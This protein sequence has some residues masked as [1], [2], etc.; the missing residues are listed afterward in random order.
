MRL[1]SNLV[2][3]T[4]YS[5]YI[6]LRSNRDAVSFWCEKKLGLLGRTLRRSLLL[7]ESFTTHCYRKTSGTVFNGILTIKPSAMTLAQKIK[8]GSP[9]PG[10]EPVTPLAL[11]A[12]RTQEACYQLH[13]T[14]FVMRS[15]DHE[16]QERGSASKEGENKYKLYY[17]FSQY[18]VS[19]R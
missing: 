16:S 5:E 2:N 12:S 15:R 3:Y 7:L 1:E 19:V 14:G 11:S 17:S 4:V 8:V 9:A 18:T 13:Q 10:L 6:G